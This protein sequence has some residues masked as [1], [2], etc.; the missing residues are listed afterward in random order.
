MVMT[1]RLVNLRGLH[2]IGT[3]TDSDDDENSEDD[4]A[5]ADLDEQSAGSY[6]SFNFLTH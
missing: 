2:Q 5:I 1:L 4:L 3:K 6:F